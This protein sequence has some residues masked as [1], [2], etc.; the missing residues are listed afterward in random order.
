VSSLLRAISSFFS[1]KI[2]HLWLAHKGYERMY[3]NEPCSCG[4][5][6]R[7]YQYV[8]N[9]GSLAEIEEIVLWHLERIGKADAK[10]W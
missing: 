4:H 1:E 9:G 3:F 7:E 6:H 10:R 5:R 8:K 2:I